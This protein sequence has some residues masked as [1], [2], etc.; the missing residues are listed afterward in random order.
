MPWIVAHR[1]ALAE[2]PENTKSSFDKALSYPIDGI[3]FDVQITRDK[4]P[5]IFHDKFI[6]KK[7]DGTGKIS[8]YSYR[9][10]YGFDWGSWFS[11]EYRGEKILTFE[12][13][14]LYYGHRT[15][16]L[17]EIKSA[18]RKDKISLYSHLPQLVTNRIRELI[19]ADLIDNIYVL[20][21]DQML[22][23]S[24]YD[25]D[26]GLHYVLNLEHPDIKPANLIMDFNMLCGFGLAFSKLTPDF[27]SWCH[28]FDKKVMTYSC[29]TPK[30]IRRAFE[31]NI[32]VIMTDAPGVVVDSF[33]T[34]KK[35]Y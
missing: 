1:G 24:A 11:E 35:E 20:S 5:V 25:T 30:R 10:L 15:R 31:L 6:H 26:P 14:L 4:I 23:T 7:S 21:F 3:E 22:L 27:V 12:Q 17:I 2:T 16:L 34:Y 28:Q 13:V 19:P 32:D 18:P 29:N 9:E 33:M 8:D